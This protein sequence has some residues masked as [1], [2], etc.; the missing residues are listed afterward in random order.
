MSYHHFIGNSLNRSEKLQ[1]RVVFELIHSKIPNKER[2]SSIEW[3]LKHSSSC[4]QMA[5]IL[6]EKRGLNIEY[7][8]IIGCLHDLAVVLTGKY[9][10]HALKGSEIAR[11]WMEISKEFSSQEIKLIS[12]A[13]AQHSD[14]HIY[15]KNPYVELAKDADVLDCFLYTDKG[16]DNKPKEKLAEYLKRIIL[17]RKELGFP[18]KKLYAE[19]L[20]GL[21]GE[22]K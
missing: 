18:E 12:D 4:A 17:I 3:E 20:L 9:E 14:K 16:Y 15:S 10:N 21:K 22:K 13:I 6:A 1:V 5:R 7:A 11:E 8:E 19:Q 2:D